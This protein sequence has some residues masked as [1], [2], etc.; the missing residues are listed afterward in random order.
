MAVQQLPSQ[1]LNEAVPA[2]TYWSKMVEVR[3]V[4]QSGCGV[5]TI[6]TVSQGAWVG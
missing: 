3:E 5:S 4:L 1:L 6:K 2:P